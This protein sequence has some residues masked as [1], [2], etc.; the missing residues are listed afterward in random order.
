VIRLLRAIG[1][2]SAQERAMPRLLLPVAVIGGCLAA[3]SCGGGNTGPQDSSD[4]VKVAIL[5]L[6]VTADTL[7]E[8]DTIRI[9]AKPRSATEELLADR[10]VTWESNDASIATVNQSGL[11]RAVDHGTATIV[12]TAEGVTSVANITVVVGVTGTWVGNIDV[13]GTICPWTQSLTETIEG[14]I[15]GAG[16]VD[17]PCIAGSYTVI[18]TN[19]TGGVPNSLHMV[20]SLDGGN[21]VLEGPFDGVSEMSG[22]VEQDSC[23]GTLCPWTF[24]RTSIIPAPISMLTAPAVSTGP[25]FSVP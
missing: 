21:L 6:S 13:V 1:D 11:V 20:L 23:T 12:A 5:E 9:E 10:T 25:G 7:A 15:T 18:G 14:T 3:I 19:N 8:G 22:F 24:T 4:P 17:L 16:F 2:P